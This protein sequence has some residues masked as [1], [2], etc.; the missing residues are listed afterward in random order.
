MRA[1]ARVNAACNAC[2][3]RQR[4]QVEASRT[5]RKRRRGLCKGA[6]SH[7]SGQPVAL[8]KLNMQ[9]AEALVL[10]LRA[11][12]IAPHLL[13]VR[14]EALLA[15]GTRHLLEDLFVAGHRKRANEPA[16]SVAALKVHKGRRWAPTN[17]L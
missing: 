9:V 10:P 6:E 13:R 5:A 11:V 17:T 4:G 7:R 1:T 15:D 12:A 14:Q 8:L 16:N 2:L 3:Q